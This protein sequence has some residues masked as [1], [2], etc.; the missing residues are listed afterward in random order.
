MCLR[1]S[2]AKARPNLL[3]R[4]RESLWVSCEVSLI[5]VLPPMQYTEVNAWG[6][7]GLTETAKT[8]TLPF[9]GQTR[10]SGRSS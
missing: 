2:H 1:F 3:S 5:S 10:I 8:D 6:Q 9:H 4:E 7:L